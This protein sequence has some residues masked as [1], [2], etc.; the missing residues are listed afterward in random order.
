MVLVVR[1][2]VMDIDRF[3]WLP[4]TS[5]QLLLI[6]IPGGFC[7]CSTTHPASAAGQ[8]R[9]TTKLEEVNLKVLVKVTTGGTMI[10]MLPL[11]QRV[12]KSQMIPDPGWAGTMMGKELV[13]VPVASGLPPLAALPNILYTWPRAKGTWL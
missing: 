1:G 8:D 12:R 2:L 3:V 13:A 10:P 9:F 4:M 5:P 11:G 6:P 7:C